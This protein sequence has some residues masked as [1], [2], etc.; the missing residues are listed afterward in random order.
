MEKKTVELSKIFD[1]QF[2]KSVTEHQDINIL[3][4]LIANEWIERAKKL[5][6]PKP[7]FGNFWHQGEIAIL[8]SNT[9]KGKS[10]LAVQLAESIADGQGILNQE[11]TCQ[12]VIYFDFEL[13]TKAF[14]RRY[15]D[16]NGRSYHFSNNFMRVEID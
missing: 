2:N 16:E 8:F 9:G 3:M 14:Q 10:I 5:L 15:T 12:R 1:N 7:L 6:N 13:S 4:N 11:T